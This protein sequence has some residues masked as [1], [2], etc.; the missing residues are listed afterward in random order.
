M[1]RTL[2][3]THTNE[4]FVDRT[5]LEVKGGRGGDGCVSFEGF[6]YVLVVLSFRV[7]FFI[8]LFDS[9]LFYC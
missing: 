9:I 6:K 1:Q 3:S 4:Q 7:I 2:I 8:T 5:K